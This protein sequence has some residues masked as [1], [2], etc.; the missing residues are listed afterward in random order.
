[1]NQREKQLLKARLEKVNADISRLLQSK[2]RTKDDLQKLYVRKNNL[3][4]WIH[5]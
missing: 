3:N 2:G 4:A 5:E 1:M